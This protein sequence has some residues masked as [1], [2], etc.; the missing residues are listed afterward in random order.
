MALRQLVGL[1]TFGLRSLRPCL[2]FRGG[3]QR[4]RLRGLGLVCEGLVAVG[5][6]MG[7]PGEGVQTERLLLPML[8]LIHI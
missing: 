8:F 3:H 4:L 1:L 7:S 2:R 6:R 5:L